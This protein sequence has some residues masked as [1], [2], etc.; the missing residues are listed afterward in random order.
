MELIRELYSPDVAML[1]IG[2][3]FTMGP[4]EAALAVKYLQPELILPIHWG[5]MPQLTGTPQELARLL[6]DNK[7][8][9]VVAPGEAL[10]S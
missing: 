7:L 4:R 6:G 10:A 8:V 5:T 9:A 3:C 2:G 1:P